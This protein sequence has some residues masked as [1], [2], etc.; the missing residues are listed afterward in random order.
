[1]IVEKIIE[2][3]VIIKNGNLKTILNEETQQRGW[4]TVDQCFRLVR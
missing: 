4:M 3:K 2:N 1:M